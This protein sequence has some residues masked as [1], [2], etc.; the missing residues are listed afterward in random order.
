MLTSVLPRSPLYITSTRRTPTS[1]PLSP[2]RTFLR[3]KKRD[4]ARVVLCAINV[5]MNA[6]TLQNTFNINPAVLLV[7]AI[8]FLLRIIFFPY[9][10]RPPR[11]NTASHPHS[12]PAVFPL[13]SL[14]THQSSAPSGSKAVLQTPVRPSRSAASGI[15]LTSVPRNGTNT[16]VHPDRSCPKSSFHPPPFRCVPNPRPLP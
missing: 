11:Q 8:D 4:V 13:D 10:L 2:D 7:R 6:M 15:D 12:I 9:Q 16:Q 1:V 5:L 3:K 14:E